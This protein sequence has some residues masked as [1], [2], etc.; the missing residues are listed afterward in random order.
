MDNFSIAVITMA[1]IV[2]I[3]YHIYDYTH[4]DI[5]KINHD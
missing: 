2:A 3:I 1:T 4:P 5:K